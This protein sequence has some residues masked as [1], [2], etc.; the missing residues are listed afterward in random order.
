[1][2]LPIE[3]QT[4]KIE[5]FNAIGFSFFIF[6]FVHPKLKGGKLKETVNHEKI[7]FQQQVELLFVLHWILYGLFYLRGRLRK[8]DH[9]QSYRKNPFEIEAYENDKD[10]EYLSKRKRYIWIKLI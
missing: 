7:H 9:K 6:I 5:I 4:D 2:K 3:I 1:M 8:L 10:L